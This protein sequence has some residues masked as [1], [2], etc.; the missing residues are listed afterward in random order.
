M[1]LERNGK[2]LLVPSSRDGIDSLPDGMLEHILGFLEAQE[3]VRMCVLAKCWR[4][5]WKS[6]SAMRIISVSNCWMELTALKKFC[7]FVDRL[8]DS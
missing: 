1:P 4:Q 5:L 3:A 2:K 8:L 7:Q 6:A